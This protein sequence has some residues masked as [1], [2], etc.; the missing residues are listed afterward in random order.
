M[1][2]ANDLSSL[3]DNNNEIEEFEHDD[4]DGLDP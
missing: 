2:N 1:M 3:I 4:D